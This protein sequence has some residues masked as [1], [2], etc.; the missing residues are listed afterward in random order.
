MADRRGNHR[1]VTGYPRSGVSGLTPHQVRF[2]L[3]GNGWAALPILR[4]DA[5]DR[6][7]GKCLVCGG[8]EEFA[9]YGADLPTLADLNDWDARFGHA[10]GTGLPM[11]N[12]VAIDL[13]FLRD[14]SLARRAYD[15]M[16]AT[17]GETP[18]VRQGQAPKTAL[19]YTRA[20]AEW[21]GVLIQFLE[22]GRHRGYGP[23]FIRI[24]PARIRYRRADV[25]AWLEARTFASTSQ[26]GTWS[27]TMRRRTRRSTA[28]EGSTR[29]GS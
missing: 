10:P 4:H 24:G 13:D 21:L 12:E 7:A 14:P 6:H 20:V 16:V 1:G 23:K 26:A 11:G 8:W 22:I 2:R 28:A 25:L 27:A 9:E 17:C 3:L 29:S 18:F 15:I 19:V 5:D